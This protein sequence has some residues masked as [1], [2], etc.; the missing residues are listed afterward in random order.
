MPDFRGSKGR[1]SGS[2]SRIGAFRG[3]GGVV[4]KV[5]HDLG[6]EAGLRQSEAVA[7]WP[8]VAG[9]KI[10]AA[11]EA[12]GI[13]DGELQV[14]CRSNVWANELSMLKPRLVKAMSEAIGKGVVKDI[15]FVAARLPKKS[16]REDEAAGRKQ[17][18]PTPALEAE[19]EEV[20]QACAEF[21]KDPGLSDR[22]RR[23]VRTARLSEAERIALGWRKCAKCGALHNERGELCAVCRLG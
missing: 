5:I 12:R 1:N 14:A 17:F 7:A 22:I 20:A 6:L 9:E 11:T 19:A 15:R 8:E 4:G 2:R 23:A 18:S 16:P 13:H 3:F 21:V 10:A